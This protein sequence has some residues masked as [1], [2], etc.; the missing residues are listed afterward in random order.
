M[1]ECLFSDAFSKVQV[2]QH[3]VVKCLR[4]MNWTRNEEFAVAYFKV[5]YH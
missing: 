5:P 4:V 1:T 2:L 3:P